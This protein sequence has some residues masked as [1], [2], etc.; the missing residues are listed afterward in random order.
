[1]TLEMRSVTMTLLAE[2]EIPGM[3][4]VAQ[5]RGHDERRRVFFL[6][7]S[8]NVGGTETQAVELALRL[9]PASYDITLGCLKQEGPLLARLHGSKVK[10]I[11][12]I[13][14]EASILRVEFTSSR[15]CNRSF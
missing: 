5:T 1:M 13:P 2:E 8:L 4:N 3:Q 10:V 15:G 6:L 14:E 12:F 11:E 7:D 9:D